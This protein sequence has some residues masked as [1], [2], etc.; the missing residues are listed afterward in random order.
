M[1][2]PI[3][4]LHLY[5]HLYDMGDKY[6]PQGKNRV[7]KSSEVHDKHVNTT[8]STNDFNT[9][10]NKFDPESRGAA[11]RAH[12]ATRLAGN[13]HTLLLRHVRAHAVLLCAKPNR[14]TL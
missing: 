13:S 2:L 14:A 3:H 10:N 7:T 5:I 12:K 1:Y 8:A 11:K 4:A 9:K 6:D